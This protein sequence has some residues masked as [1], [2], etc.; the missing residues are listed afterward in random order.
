MSIH[1]LTPTRLL[2]GY[3]SGAV[4]LYEY[5]GPDGGV[6]DSRLPTPP[7]RGKWVVRWKTKI[8]NEAGEANL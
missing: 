6:T 1:L 2:A 3:E 4:V 7:G 8:H 5:E